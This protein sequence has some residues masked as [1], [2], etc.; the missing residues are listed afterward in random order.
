[1]CAVNNLRCSSMLSAS[2]SRAAPPPAVRSRAERASHISLSID[3]GAAVGGSFSR[4]KLRSAHAGPRVAAWPSSPSL[5]GIITFL[6]D[7]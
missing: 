2:I 5:Q 7:P 6:V 1:M 4:V 3:A